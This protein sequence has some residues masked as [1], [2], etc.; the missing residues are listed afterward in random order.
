MD[1]AQNRRASYTPAVPLDPEL[2]APD[3]TAVIVSE[4]QRMVVGDRSMLPALVEAAA[5]I[6][7]NIDRLLMAA[8]KAGVHVVHGTVDRRGDGKGAARN[9]RFAG[10]NERRRREGAVLDP[11]DLEIVP[12]ISVEASDIVL[13]RLH[14]MTPLTDTGLDGILRSLGVT[15]IVA[16]GVSLNVALAGTVIG[17]VDRGYNVVM[18]KDAVAGVPPEYGRAM[19][20]NTFAMVTRLTTTDELAAIWA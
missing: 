7:P 3:H 11:A 4:C 20:E 1:P 6:L 9:T 8:R 16:T 17:A 12:E 13:S 14:G 10:L 15:T 2:V 19:L 5:E 18:P